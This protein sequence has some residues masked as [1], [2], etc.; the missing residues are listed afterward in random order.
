MG[1]LGRSGRGTR[2]P[3]EIMAELASA[4]GRDLMVVRN[5]AG[6]RTLI[7]RVQELRAEWLPDAEVPNAGAQRRAIEAENSL[8][9]AELMA[10]AA[11]MRQE[12]R[13]SHFREDYPARD[14]DRWRVNIILR[15]RDG[16]LELRTGTLGNES[17]AE[18]TPFRPIA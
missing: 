1:R 11:L 15:Q 10:Q 2:N 14:D 12:S 7:A 17:C 9:T 8:V 5:E 13:G 3:D 16:R 4:A 18:G 6:L